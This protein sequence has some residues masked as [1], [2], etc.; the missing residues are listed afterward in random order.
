M[1]TAKF[2]HTKT[3]DMA[4][5]NILK[6]ALIG[7]GPSSYEFQQSNLIMRS[8]KKKED[9]TYQFAETTLQGDRN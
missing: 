4:Y 2:R 9:E 3:S 6:K 1:Q 7:T 8:N 5:E